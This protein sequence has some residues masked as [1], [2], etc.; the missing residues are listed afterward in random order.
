[1]YKISYKQKRIFGLDILRAVAIL[2]VVY[3]HGYECFSGSRLSFSVYALPILLDGVSIFFVL[4]GFLVGGIIIK[5]SEKNDL[6]NLTGLFA[7]WKR[8]WLRTLPNYYVILFLLFFYCSIFLNNFYPV[9]YI[10]KYIFFVQ[11]FSYWPGT[12][13]REAWSLS[14]EEW[15]YLLFPITFIIIFYLCNKNKKKSVF[16]T[17]LI[18]LIIP[19][20][21]RICVYM[22]KFGMS[23]NEA[24]Y[25]NIVV[26][27][28]DSIAYGIAGAFISYYYR[29]IW[30]K[31]KKVFL[32]IAIFIF[33]LLKI[34]F[35]L[36]H[37]PFLYSIFIRPVIRDVLIL[38]CLPYFSTYQPL[39]NNY[40]HKIVTY[41]SVISYSMYL[42][43]LTP[44]LLII[45]PAIKS[46]FPLLQ[47][48]Q[49]VEYL[50]Y[51]ILTI[52]LSHILYISIEKPMMDLRDMPG[53]NK[54]HL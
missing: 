36:N 12:F 43:N 48:H 16:I 34:Y 26:F 18:F 40:F 22:Y 32:A 53:K 27:R 45:L 15:F 28:L 29:Q 33:A 2:Y 50:I 24:Y 47:H 6:L 14:V 25:R 44:V 35:F 10:L 17:T 49:F 31:N 20:I 51:W 23:N 37:E 7:F 8:R 39:R 9:R 41:L 3:I 42:L 4:S 11:N 1:M 30:I 38:L 54:L 21:L 5:L 19:F 13:F 46:K 52:I